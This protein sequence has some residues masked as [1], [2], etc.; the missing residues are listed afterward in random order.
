MF[1][2]FIVSRYQ[3]LSSAHFCKALLCGWLQKFTFDNT[4]VKSYRI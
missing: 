4:L 3:N 2:Y 1:Q